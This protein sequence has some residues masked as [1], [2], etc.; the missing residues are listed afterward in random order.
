MRLPAHQRVIGD[1]AIDQL[2]EFMPN[3]SKIES[4]VKIAHILAMEN[5]ERLS[6]DHVKT[7]LK[8]QEN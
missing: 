3:G 6:L 5:K 2:A 4:A 1:Q 8:L 7:V